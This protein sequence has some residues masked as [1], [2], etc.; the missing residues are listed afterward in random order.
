MV[1]V[2]WVAPCRWWGASANGGG[3]MAKWDEQ[4]VTIDLDAHGLME[5]DALLD[6]LDALFA[7]GRETPEPI[8]QCVHCQHWGPRG[9]LVCWYCSNWVHH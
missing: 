2:T 3:I 9:T 7:H 1:V 8:D 6:R 4:R 5:I